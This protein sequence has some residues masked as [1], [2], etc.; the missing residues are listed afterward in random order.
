M[1]KR[2]ID[3]WQAFFSL[4]GITLGIIPLIQIGFGI[5]DGGLWQ[6]VFSEDAGPIR[7]IVPLVVL[8]GAIIAVLMLERR[9]P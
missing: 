3:G 6:I 8:V 9:K 4:I 5:G 7:W 2:A 1:S